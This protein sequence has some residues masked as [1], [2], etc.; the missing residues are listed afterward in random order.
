MLFPCS[1]LGADSKSNEIAC[2]RFSTVLETRFRHDGS[3]ARAN[4]AAK[5]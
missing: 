2:S 4:R 5:L 1:H 3:P